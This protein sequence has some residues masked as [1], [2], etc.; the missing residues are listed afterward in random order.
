MKNRTFPQLG[1][2]FLYFLLNTNSLLQ[3]QS[4]ANDAGISAILRPSIHFCAG[5]DSVEVTLKNYGT[6]TLRSVY[7]SFSTKGTSLYP[8]SWYGKLP[9]D[10]TVNLIP[11][12]LNFFPTGIYTVLVSTD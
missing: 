9:P 2:A 12:I 5:Y 3:A 8:Y 7:I 11:F 6:D 1:V 10:S 4:Y